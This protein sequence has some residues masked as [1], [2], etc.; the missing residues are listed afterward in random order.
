MRRKALLANGAWECVAGCLGHRSLI[1]EQLPCREW[2]LPH[3]PPGA[4]SDS[5]KDEPREAFV[6]EA[7]YV[8]N[9]QDEI[10]PHKVNGGHV[11][12]PPREA[13]F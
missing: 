11:G 1:P 3:K 6:Q 2:C 13:C 12:A 9:N 7:A 5:R 8:F 4:N 10:P